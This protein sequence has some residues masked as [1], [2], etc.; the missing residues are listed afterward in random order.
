MNAF[1][2]A[3]KTVQAALQTGQ[4]GQPV[5]AR[6]TAHMDADHGQIE[7][8]MTRVLSAMT[9]WFDSRPQRI[10]AFGSVEAGNVST[11]TL[12]EN[13]QSALVSVGCCA[14]TDPL[15]ELVVWGNHG[16]LS[17]EHERGVQSDWQQE[18]DL[19]DVEKSLCQQLQTS[20]RSG[21][22]VLTSGSGS[23]PPA[24]DK[25]HRIRPDQR[26][27]GMA[28][29]A[30]L[31]AQKPPYGVLLVSGDHTHQAQYA[32]SLANDDRCRLIGLT[33]EPDLPPRRRRLNQQLAERLGIPLLPDLH[34]AI[35]R[36][37]VH[38]VSVCAEPFR[39][40]GI[41]VDAARAG[42]HLYLDKPLAATLEEA[43]A[44]RK[45]V[46]ESGVVSH[47]WSFSHTNT[48]DR[49]QRELRSDR[50][51]DLRAF[52]ADLCFA[53]GPA[54]TAALENRRHENP[55]PTRYELVE[56]KRELTNVGVYS[57][58]S[59]LSSQNRSV[60][61]VCA[62]TGN[63]FFGEHQ[64]NDM[65]DF[66]Q[67]L[68]EL[69]DGVVATISAGRT[70]WQSNPGGGFDRTCLVGT[71]QTSVVDAHRPRVSVWA[72]A[73]PWVPP[74]RDPEDPMGMWGGAPRED[75]FIPQPRQTWITPPE[76]TN[77]DAAWFLDCIETGRQSNISADIA[78]AATEI[79]LAVYQSAASGKVVDLPL[80]RNPE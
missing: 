36:D 6:V 80:P 39:R 31:T 38:I 42:K 4:V 66:G 3:S 58:V 50:L 29:P 8:L 63:Y 13:G 12:F 68:L 10:T 21:C 24:A 47:M 55:A 20:L 43:E 74:E 52:H 61:R 64:T 60:R 35:R 48:A 72:D 7:W 46:R 49:L 44:I 56:S 19:T 73:D 30:E 26:H 22:S 17:W 78:A 34:D 51:G 57:L 53:K 15:L 37:D 41:I 70:G 65:E 62:T 9:T 23:S 69:D 5:A 67:M 28:E 25:S 2:A 1:D 45:A 59:L 32:V 14:A 27:A 18:S 79:L 11:L 33:D 40:A 16:I 54:G 76:Q 75:Q 77:R 71:R